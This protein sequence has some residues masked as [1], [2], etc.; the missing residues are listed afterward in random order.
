VAGYDGLLQSGHNPEPAS[1]WFPDRPEQRINTGQSII[2]QLS[3][4]LQR[5]ILI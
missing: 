4:I 1:R 5:R 3:S 2:F